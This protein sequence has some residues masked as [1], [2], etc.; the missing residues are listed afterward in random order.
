MV[1]PSHMQNVSPRQ[2]GDGGS[3][4]VAVFHAQ[5]S[6]AQVAGAAMAGA[7]L[8]LPSRRVLSPTPTGSTRSIESRPEAHSLHMDSR[9]RP[10]PSE[11]FSPRQKLWTLWAGRRNL[12]ALDHAVALALLVLEVICWL[13]EKW[14]GCVAGWHLYHRI[15]SHLLFK[16]F[17]REV[18]VDDPH[19]VLKMAGNQ[20]LIFCSNH[21]TGLL[22]RLLIQYLSPRPCFCLTQNWFSYTNHV[23]M[24][25]HVVQGLPFTRMVECLDHGHALWIAVGG[26][27]ELNPYIR[28]VHTGAARIALQAARCS[29]YEVV[30]VPLHLCFEAHC[31]FNSAVLVELGK[32]V[33]VE[34]GVDPDSVSGREHVHGLTAALKENLLPLTNWIPAKPDVNYG[35]KGSR[36]V[37]QTRLAVSEW[38]LIRVIDTLVCLHALSTS[39]GP[40][41]WNARVR[42][43]RAVAQHLS[44][45]ASEKFQRAKNAFQDFAVAVPEGKL[46]SV[47]TGTY[48][49][50]PVALKAI[51]R[52]NPSA[53]PGLTLA[54]LR[55]FS[56]GPLRFAERPGDLRDLPASCTCRLA[57]LRQEALQFIE[58]VMASVQ[59]KIEADAK[60]CSCTYE[61]LAGPQVTSRDSPRFHPVPSM[62]AVASSALSTGSVQLL[63]AN[64]R[65]AASPVP[66]RATVGTFTARSVSPQRTAWSMS[67]PMG[68]HAPSV[69]AA[70]PGSRALPHTPSVVQPVQ[71]VM[72]AAVQTVQPTNAPAPRWPAVGIAFPGATLPPGPSHQRLQGTVA[73][74]RD[75]VLV[76]ILIICGMTPQLPFARVRRRRI[77][78]RRRN[79]RMRESTFNI[80]RPLLPWN[81]AMVPEGEHTQDAAELSEA[82]MDGVAAAANEA[83]AQQLMLGPAVALAPSSDSIRAVQQEG[84]AS[85]QDA[86]SQKTCQRLRAF[87][88][89][90]LSKACRSVEDDPTQK[91][92]LF[93]RDI[94]ET[95]ASKTALETRFELQLPRTNITETALME[96][97]HGRVGR[98]SDARLW[99]FTAMV[100]GLVRS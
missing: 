81:A 100:A 96:V 59:C 50:M 75:A 14:T 69:R 78:P 53:V 89:E 76:C 68:P 77:A 87:V 15:V 2:A 18:S 92:T 97:L 86:L 71:C 91:Y 7:R 93:S 21:P 4:V 64:S 35:K 47:A 8:T 6:L 30:L 22:D 41:P 90:E 27:R 79:N 34:H 11:E 17:F 24:C 42:R 49:D 23:E 28:K 83:A 82:V 60:R 29:E 13:L 5:A 84:V 54:P 62:A 19:R 85:I 51:P 48:W 9:P 31:Q 67:L 3:R 39:N 20:R 45:Q 43:V 95:R 88:L 58:S 70:S 55:N 56:S 80:D 57:D 94:R 61:V 33:H 74:K 26:S 65:A 36:G 98:G 10:R 73:M 52:R 40:I 99:E 72:R 1:W 37:G 46:F 66:M 44:D 38:Y 12:E 63:T 25:L 32:P 16:L